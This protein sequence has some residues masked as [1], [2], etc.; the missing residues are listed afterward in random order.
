MSI[1][2][3]N[4]SFTYVNVKNLVVI[5][6]GMAYG[7]DNMYTNQK[8]IYWDKSTPNVLIE[9]N[10]R[11]EQTSMRFL[12]IINN[13]GISTVMPHDEI[14]LSFD[15][16]ISFGDGGDIS[17]GEF[18]SL[19]QEVSNNTTKY[20][21]V[22]KDVDKI[23]TI[24][25]DETKLEDGTLVQNINA[26]K[27]SSTSMESTIRELQ[28]T[29]KDE[30]KDIRDAIAGTLTA[31]MTGLSELNITFNSISKDN[32]IDNEEITTMTDSINKINSEYNDIITCIDK[33]KEI[34][35]ANAMTDEIR[36]LEERLLSVDTSR[37][38]VINIISNVISDKQVT[39]TEMTTVTQ[40]VAAAGIDVGNLKAY[41]D[42]IVTLGLGG[43]V[44]DEFS[45]ISQYKNEISMEVHNI[46]QNEK[47]IKDTFSQFKQTADGFYQKVEEHTETLKGVTRDINNI[48]E[49]ID[50]TVSNIDTY[51]SKS[52][53]EFTPGTDWSTDIPTYDDRYFIWSKVVTTYTDGTT[54][55]TDPIKLGLNGEDGIGID[56]IEQWYYSST[57]NTELLNGTWST[58][59]PQ[60]KSGRFIWTKQRI[61]YSD[62]TTSETS[63]LCVTGEPGSSGINPAS[64][65]LNSSTYVVPYGT[66]GNPKTTNDIV[67]TAIQQN[68]TDE[69]VW[70]TSEV[71]TLNGN[72]NTRTIIPSDFN[73]YDKVTITVAGGGL[74]DSVTIVKVVDGEEG[75]DAYT[76]VLSNEAH[77]F[78]GDST[79]A[80]SQS[81]TCDVIAYK[82]TTRVPC[83]IGTITG[84]PIG[85]TIPTHSNN[86]TTAARFT[87]NVATSMT[88]ESGV[89]N[90]PVTV[91]GITFTK[92]F[93]YTLAL[94]G[95][96][97]KS[98]DL[99]SSS[100]AV[101][102]DNDNN[103]KNTN[104]I[105]INAVARNLRGTIG[106]SVSP[107]D[108]TL[109]TSSN[110]SREIDPSSFKKYESI[111]VTASCDTYSD[112]ITIVK[113]QDGS[114]GSGV[115]ILGSYDTEAELLAAHPSGNNNG[116]AYIVG[117]D[118]YIWTGSEFKNVGQFKGKDGLDGNDG[119][120]VILSNESH[121]FPGDTNSANPGSAK[122]Y[123]IGYKGTTQMPVTIGNI[124][125]MPTGMNIPAH[126]NNNT[127]NAYFTVNVTEDMTTKNGTLNIPVTIDGKIFN[128]TFSYS[129]A[130]TGGD[131]VGINRIDDE[132]I[133]TDSATT[134]PSAN[135]TGWSTTAPK[136]V[137]GKYIWRRTKTYYTNNNTT[138]SSPVC[139]T[140]E[141]G[142][143]PRYLS[144]DAST[145]V[146]G[147]D[148]DGAIKDTTQIELN[149]SEENFDMDVTWS[150]NPSVTLSGTD[151]RT[152]TIDPSIFETIDK[153]TVTVTA[154]NMSD[155][156]TIV[157][158]QDGYDGDDA[159]TIMLSNESHTFRGST[160]PIASSTTTKIIAL[161]YN[162]Q[163][164][165][166]V[167]TISDIPSGMKITTS[168]NGT[169]NTT[170]NISIDKTITQLN[171]TI[172]IPITVNSKTFTKTFSYSIVLNGENGKDS[173]TWIKY[174]HNPDGSDMTDEPTTEYNNYF[175]TYTT[176]TDSAGWNDIHF[177]VDYLTGTFIISNLSITIPGDTT[178]YAKETDVQMVGLD[179]YNQCYDLG[180]SDV[181]PLKGKNVTISFNITVIN[182]EKPFTFLIQQK[183]VDENGVSASW[184]YLSD[185]INVFLPTQYIGIAT[186][187]NTLTESNDPKDYTW[188]KFIGDNGSDSITLELISDTYVVPYNKDG[189]LKKTDDIVLTALSGGLTESI[190][191]TTEPTVTLTTDSDGN[192]LLNPT[193]FNSNDKIKVTVT[194][195]EYTDSV[196][197]V[198]VNDGEF[199]YNAV[200]SNQAHTF[201]GDTEKAI[202][203]KTT[204]YV[205]GYDGTSRVVTNIGTITG[206]PT[207]MTVSIKNNNTNKA[208]FEVSVTTSMKTKSG[209]LKV[210]VTI[211]SHLI[212][213]D[214]SYTLA[215][216][217]EWGTGVESI[218]EEYNISDSKDTAPTTGW[219]TT[220]PTWEYGK[221]LWIRN[222][223]TY[224]NPTSVEY[225]EPYCDTTWE[226]IE[227]L[228]CADRNLIKNSAFIYGQEPWD[229]YLN[230]G[231]KIDTNKTHYS[232][233]SVN[234]S[235][236]GLTS[237][238]WS[239][240]KNYEILDA[241]TL[242]E[243][244][245]YTL[246]AWY[247][248]EDM[249]TIDM[250]I[251]IELK[252]NG[253]GSSGDTAIIQISP[254]ELKEKEWC[255][256]TK[257]V[258]ITKKYNNCFVYAWVRR[259]GTI[260]FTDFKLAKG[261][262][263]GDWSPAPEDTEDRLTTTITK[264]S[265]HTQ[266][267][268]EMTDK[269]ARVET[270]ANEAK[271]TAT[272]AKQTADGFT[273]KVTS[274]E[275]TVKGHTEKIS[276]IEQT[277]SSIKSSVS[278][279]QNMGN[280]NLLYNTEF[281]NFDYWDANSTIHCGSGD[282]GI[283][284]STITPNG[285]ASFRIDE[286]NHTEDTWHGYSQYISGGLVPGETYTLSGYY[287]VFS[288]TSSGVNC[289][290]DRGIGIEIKGTKDGSSNVISG[291]IKETFDKIG[292]WVKFSITFTYPYNYASPLVF[293][294]VK[295]NG[296]LYTGDLML[297]KGS[298]SVNWMPSPSDNDHY[299]ESLVTQ[300]SDAIKYEFKM[301]SGNPNLCPNSNPTRY[302]Y[303]GW[304]FSNAEPWLGSGFE[305]YM[306][307]GSRSSSEGFLW[308]PRIGVKPNT[309]YSISFW[310]LTEANVADGFDFYIY[311]EEPNKYSGA[312]LNLQTNGGWKKIKVSHITSDS[313]YHM[314]L[315]FDNNGDGSGSKTKYLVILCDIMI[316][317]GWDYFPSVWYPATQEIMSNT[318]TIN[319]SGVEVRHA[320]NSRTLLDSSALNF[321]DNTNILYSQ[322]KDGKLYYNNTDGT[323]VGYVGRNYWTGTSTYLSA[324][325]AE[326]G[327]CVGLGVKFDSSSNQ[328]QTNI[329]VSSKQQTLGGCCARQGLNLLNPWVKGTIALEDMGSYDASPSFITSVGSDLR[330]FG[331]SYITLG[332]RYGDDNYPSIQIVEA[333]GFDHKNYINVYGDI[334]MHGH[335]IS[336]S[337][338]ASVT[339][340]LEPTNI[341]VL[342]TVK[343]ADE[344]GTTSQYSNDIWKMY[345][346]NSLTENE[347]RWTDRK[348]HQ[349][350]PVN[351]YDEN[352]KIIGE[353][354]YYDVTIE[355]PYYMSD[356]IEDDYHISIT[357]NTYGNYRV[358]ER[359]RYYFIV[360]SDVDGF[361]FT[362]EV[363]AKKLDKSNGQNIVVA[364]YGITQE[365]QSFENKERALGIS[366]TT[367]ELLYPSQLNNEE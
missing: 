246:S 269:V 340:I 295:R 64:L 189:N 27:Q 358:K 59:K 214:F 238:V 235:K 101:L 282:S 334:R 341:G 129:I 25:G 256:V 226:A 345:T 315:R 83:T 277:N 180:L 53:D 193:V 119:Y 117:T 302:N 288:V 362:F 324:I 88:T 245:V 82:G 72:G 177:R 38:N 344:S 140:G 170:L 52:T 262:K 233:P 118:M 46:E 40:A 252:G 244:E 209:V 326:Y 213:L 7:I 185:I 241:K 133:Q 333:E 301:H 203:A 192:K 28:E 221:Y 135:D 130:F 41:V 354:D 97:A 90:V 102:F 367:G 320:D 182:Q 151:N 291:F 349:T 109:T 283:V 22:S 161:K 17:R 268:D 81:T 229:F 157:K 171:G 299:T 60:N 195:G 20:N 43:T 332:I 303:K 11:L 350:S 29:I 131:G 322:V 9:S 121:V 346:T 306:A 296:R 227:D 4:P 154:S 127:N 30:F 304:S 181:T 106:W 319:G 311:E 122:C 274:I 79:S 298:A 328:Y 16:G 172:N 23:T 199:A 250:G 327:H 167:G 107:S 126:G 247:Y 160:E 248:V 173:Y 206:M 116:D 18:E 103:P 89:L 104:K 169:T 217:G 100:Y 33:L 93:S 85:M 316:C 191:W 134:P 5:F 176:T 15:S 166:S 112:T 51:Y 249:S 308:S 62:G 205:Y 286:Y 190:T 339:N 200:L 188:S 123:V 153:V 218:E 44:Y 348:V 49:K 175:L 12:I 225:T 165:T 343:S 359:N 143:S 115:D 228:E 351:I 3:N 310:V 312:I 313:T 360:E 96:D 138:T 147:A 272:E 293:V 19:R 323:G 179:M 174:S 239:G 263:I 212:T 261:N 289:L 329:I 156:V 243:G 280:R 69:L 2:D 111:T 317:E 50:K 251:G 162:E 207:G 290:P 98:L 219:S 150:T 355:I 68:Y 281:K 287:K 271:S 202:A 163:Q 10:I 78:R 284:D 120:T 260:W 91:D 305:N 168:D 94:A 99:Y 86:G 194:S 13:K 198:R 353:E 366:Q 259:N 292:E 258:K 342:S 55:E 255:K 144:L 297:V 337:G 158:V 37:N 136:W 113:V 145:Y 224:N 32:T 363:V 365:N 164:I 364:N 142:E 8:Y 347:I 178:N 267:L 34:M 223:I 234:I 186:N 84:M 231:I 71:V 146:V 361:A 285:N 14:T 105:T 35:T 184:L 74:S 196:T 321:Y 128:K 270:T 187:K 125:G 80:V 240:V 95:S 318:T 264:V 139:I 232:R 132:F 210:P 204:S 75:S 208:Y 216:K 58:V 222:K 36:V 159:Y 6:E 237:D 149:V 65:R 87:V 215:L 273:N 45:K 141:K 279:L 254:T 336:G 26:I 253:E 155:S 309:S 110:S 24:L 73:S 331:D 61:Y 66:D 137:S 220:Q 266:T 76:I 108:V 314:K 275:D 236:T 335:S 56:K 278:E 77:T 152:K 57:S 42:E 201:L 357:P 352:Y 54:S 338:S 67:L 31:Y 48:K 63:E 124:T 300:T 257:T 330:I 230:S 265:E 47:E 356:N 39:T 325:N 211:N 307:F 1:L 242:N 21:T 197:I 183:G 114:D 148:K 70:S 294:W 92:Q 276:K